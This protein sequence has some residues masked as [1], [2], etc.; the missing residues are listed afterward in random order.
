[1]G[2]NLGKL[3]LFLFFI[4]FLGCEKT[5]DKTGT[6]M[7]F[8]PENTALVLKISNWKGLQADIENNPLLSKFNKSAPYLF[9]SEE[10]TLLKN[11]HPQSESLLCITRDDNS[12]YD[13]TFISRHTPNLF[14]PDSL[15]D[16]VIE[17][18]EI[19]DQTLQRITIE[20]KTSYLAIVD[21]VFVASS[22][23]K[24]L[25]DILNG[26][27]ERAEPFKKV[28]ELP[29]ASDLTILV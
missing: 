27:T 17:T 13:F 24:I 18:L 25:M 11:L 3:I 20:Q 26:R 29:F 8:I 15:R 22:S 4:A 14:Q 28:F 19:E 7:D 16:K 9:L 1:M 21:S 10:A 12:F 2:K 23:Q 5:P 6:L